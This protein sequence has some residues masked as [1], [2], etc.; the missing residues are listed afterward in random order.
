MEV[1]KVQCENVKFARD[2]N[3][4]ENWNNASKVHIQNMDPKVL[5][6]WP[7]IA[8][9]MCNLNPDDYTCTCWHRLG[10]TEL[11]NDSA[12]LF[13]LKHAGEWKNSTVSK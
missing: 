11:A 12:G 10:V 7:R 3:A 8:T 6:E 2:R 1:I 5:N 13:K 9:K 4:Y